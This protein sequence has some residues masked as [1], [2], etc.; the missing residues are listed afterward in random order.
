MPG[1]KV[2]AHVTQINVLGTHR[3]LFW[4][5]TT[6]NCL[7]RPDGHPCVYIGDKPHSATHNYTTNQPPHRRELTKHSTMNNQYVSQARPPQNVL[8]SMCARATKMHAHGNS[9]VTFAR[10]RSFPPELAGSGWPGLAA[11]CVHNFPSSARTSADIVRVPW[12]DGWKVA[13]LLLLLT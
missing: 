2:P 1:F 6:Y 5:R 9:V 4:P 7:R 10:T 8:C 11:S 3:I 12:C 13:L